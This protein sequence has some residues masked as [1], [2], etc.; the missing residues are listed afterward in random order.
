VSHDDKLILQTEILPLL[1]RNFFVGNGAPPAPRWPAVPL[2]QRPQ[3]WDRSACLP[4]GPLAF[5]RPPCRRRIKGRYLCRP[6]CDKVTALVGISPDLRVPCSACN[7]PKFVNGRCLR[8]AH[9]VQRYGLMGIAAKAADLKVEISRVQS[10]AEAGRW[11]SRSFETEHALVPGDT[12]QT[13]SFLPSLGRALRRMPN[14]TAVDALSRLRAHPARMRQWC[15]DRQ[16]ATA[17]A[18]SAWAHKARV[19]LLD[20][21]SRRPAHRQPQPGKTHGRG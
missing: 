11:L 13:V 17:W 2:L 7:A 21:L 9:D 3:G 4:R 19:R 14:R 8:S 15:V 5:P 18:L 1:A 20:T 16:A 10:V 6:Q 12:R